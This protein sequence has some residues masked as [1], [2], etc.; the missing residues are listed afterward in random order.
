MEWDEGTPWYRPTRVNHVVSG[1]DYGWRQG[2][3]KWPGYF[4]DSLPSNLDIGLGSPTAIAFGANSHFPEAY[5]NALF[6][7]DWAYGKI[8][9]VHLT[10][11]GASYHGRF[12]EFVTGRPL[13]VTGAD[14]GPDG[15][16]LLHDRWP[17]YPVWPVSSSLYRETEG[18]ERTSCAWPDAF[19]SREAVERVAPPFGSFHS[20][21]SVRDLAWLGIT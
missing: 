10:P 3:D 14:F 19:G 2:T 11:D 7:L 1:G 6:I 5:R 17:A 9:A 13:N 4:P 21:Q 15:R 12:E 8:F 16:L 18:G 20:E